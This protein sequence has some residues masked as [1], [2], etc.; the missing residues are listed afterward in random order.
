MRLKTRLVGGAVK[1]EARKIHGKG[2]MVRRIAPFRF[3]AVLKPGDGTTIFHGERDNYPDALRCA[4]SGAFAAGNLDWAK[5]VR[6]GKLMG[7]DIPY[8]YI[9]P[10]ENNDDL[11]SKG[12]Y[13]DKHKYVV[14]TGEVRYCCAI[15]F[16]PTSKLA[17]YQAT[18][19]TVKI[20]LSYVIRN[21]ESNPFF[22]DSRTRYWLHKN[23][24]A[25][26][27]SLLK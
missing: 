20:A 12:W 9:H 6:W 15:R 1:E 27:C 11:V 7:L 25:D 2:W 17:K 24:F 5:T 23:G 10:K 21:R 19:P 4:I 26:L 16:G 8:T 3:Q 13:I 18:R 22:N 14:S